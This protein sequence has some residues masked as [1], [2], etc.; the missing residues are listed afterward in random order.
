MEPMSRS[1]AR[2][3]ILVE[4][5]TK[6]PKVLAEHG[7]AYWIDYAGHH[8]LF[9]TGQGY[10]LRHNATALGIPLNSVEAIVLSHG[11]YD[12]TGG[13][14][15]VLS[16]GEAVDVFTHPAAFRPKFIRRPTGAPVFIGIPELACKN[17]QRLTTYIHDVNGPT[18]ICPGLT[19]TG[20][21]PRS[22][23]FEKTPP[24]FFLDESC[25]VADPLEDDQAVFFTTSRGLVI[26]LG[27]AHVGVINTISYIEQLMPGQPIHALIGGMHLLEAPQERIQWT[28]KELEKRRIQM[29][30][31]AHCTGMK[32]TVAIWQAFPE[33]CSEAYVGTQW[34]FDL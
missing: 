5:T 22:H 11:H 25:C 8:I 10:V 26:L 7:L 28:V 15:E 3:T 6:Q 13:I 20:P 24:R 9:D 34:E 23:E 31:P 18:T 17:L 29:I 1:K 21:I 4:N 32:A 19:A 12:H 16:G 30:A 33:C 14:T 27:C 2:V